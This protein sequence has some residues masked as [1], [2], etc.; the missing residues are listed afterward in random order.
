[1]TAEGLSMTGVL[2]A[3]REGEEIMR[4]SIWFMLACC[5]ALAPG[6]FA[7]SGAPLKLVQTIPMPGVEGR[8]DHLSADVKGRRLFVS[9]LGNDTVEVL[10]LES[11]KDIHSITGLHE[12][13]GV[14]YVPES[15]RIFIAN[16]GDGSVDVLDGRSYKV[17]STVHFPSDADDIRYDAAHKLV[18]VGYGSGGL[19]VL[20]GMTGK[21]LGTIPLRG[22][23]EAFE[24]TDGGARIY[25]NVPTAKE[26]AVA[27]WSRRSVIQHWPLANYHD[28]FPMA[29]DEA[30]HRLFVVCRRPAELLVLDTETGKMVEH[31]AVASDADD[32][33]YDEARRRI[34]VSGGQGVITVVD[35]VDADHCRLRDTVSTA[36]GARTS[37]F[38]PALSRFYLAV[39]HRGARGAEM[40]VYA[41]NN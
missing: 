1:M 18:Y 10:D 34:Y 7:Q 20:D 35:Q 3:A 29:I 17:L 21:E 19:G 5:F 36:P 25:V 22:H 41:V 4:K 28:N 31:L 24:V 15:G 11:G 23:P 30:K 9:A 8:I 14:F 2:S 39:P 13:Q 33:Y 16:G 37:L 6:L 32:V 12:P 38:V 40:R 26:I 27:D